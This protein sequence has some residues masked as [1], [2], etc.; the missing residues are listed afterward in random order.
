MAAPAG[1][2]TAA[3]DAGEFVETVAEQTSKDIF[4]V[5]ECRSAAARHG[6]PHPGDIAEPSSLS[7]IPLPPSDYPLWD[8]L[9][10]VA[11]AGKLS[12]LQLEGVLYAVSL[13]GCTPPRSLAGPPVGAIPTGAADRSPCCRHLPAVHQAPH[14]AALGRALRLLH[15]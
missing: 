3:L 9:G 15:R 12:C 1:E 11:A 13:V 6:H 4:S 8:A 5:Y 2:V 14:L 10:G 7:A